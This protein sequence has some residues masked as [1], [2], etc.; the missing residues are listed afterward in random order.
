MPVGAF[1]C[2]C[3]GV[4]LEF[5][6]VEFI[7][8]FNPWGL[9]LFSRNIDTPSQVRDLVNQFRAITG[10][11]NAPVLIDQEGGRVQRMGPPHWPAYP[12]ASRYSLIYADNPVRA[13]RLARLVARLMAHDLHDAGI[14]VNCLPVLDIPQPGSHEIIG[15]RAYGVTPG[16][17]CMLA[18][19]A[20]SGLAQ[21]GVGGVIKHIPGHGR[22]LADSHETLPVVDASRAE[23]EA[24]DFVPFAAF[25]DISMAMTAHVVYSAIDPD[26]PATMSS[27]IIEN[28]IRKD[29]GFD[30]LLMSDD[31]SMKA[32]EGSMEQRAGDAI[33]AGCDIALHCNG[34]LDEMFAVAKGAGNLEGDAARRAGA[35]IDAIQPPL[36]FD[37]QGALEELQNLCKAGV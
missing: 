35:A 20:V 26:N 18:R 27:R 25:A 12:A 3:A 32:L 4:S 13:L 6:E 9:I 15:D 11:Q 30:G 10:R 24:T 36:Q 14:N 33:S 19:A 31:L 21:G 37:R 29:M 28:I 1:I 8:E 23:L 2:G 5:D 22:A 34:K 17:V 16:R 7:R